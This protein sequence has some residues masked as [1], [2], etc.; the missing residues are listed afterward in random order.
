MILFHEKTPHAFLVL[1]SVTELTT[2]TTTIT[3]TTTTTT[4]TTAHL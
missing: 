4:T 1:H 2:T 3:T